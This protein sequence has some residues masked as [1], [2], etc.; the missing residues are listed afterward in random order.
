[1]SAILSLRSSWPG[2]SHIKHLVVFGASYCDVGYNSK[3]PHPSSDRPLGVDFPGTTWCGHYDKAT[4]TMTSEPNWVGHLVSHAQS[5]RDGLG[6]PLLV[7]DYALGGDMVAGV[8][9]QV[10]GDFLPH[11]A[12]RPARAAQW[13]GGDTLFATWVGINDCA[14]AASEPD[15]AASTRESVRTLFGLQ[16][17]LYAAGGRSFCF[18]DVPPTYDFPGRILPPRLKDAVL[19]WNAGLRESASQFSADHPDA[20][21]MIWSSWKFFSELLATP[22][23]FGFSKDDGAKEEGAIFEDGLHPTSAVHRLI[24]EQLLD[25]FPDAGSSTESRPE[26]TRSD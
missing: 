26:S 9:R 1:M 5:N 4:G 24:S 7:Y 14:W 2:F 6:S 15:P 18:V 22:E 20:T 11:L 16:E 13:V 25:F 19:S 23:A 10:H 8:A 21:V 12:T 3:S 17:E